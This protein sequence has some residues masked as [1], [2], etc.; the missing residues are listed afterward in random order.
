MSK[1]IHRHIYFA[2]SEKD[3]LKPSAVGKP[4]NKL[5]GIDFQDW[6]ISFWWEKQEELK[7]QI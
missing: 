7:G 6:F 3:I 4:F 5:E 1:Y 2:I